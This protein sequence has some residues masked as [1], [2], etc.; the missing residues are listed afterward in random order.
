MS[1]ELVLPLD[2]KEFS[3]L[4]HLYHAISK[5]AGASLAERATRESVHALFMRRIND[6]ATKIVA[7]VAATRV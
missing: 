7:R 3:E 4:A 2:S 6:E 5:S 1:K